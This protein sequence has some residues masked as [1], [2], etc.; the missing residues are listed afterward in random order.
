MYTRGQQSDIRS[1]PLRSNPLD[2]MW[3]T[4][5]FFPILTHAVPLRCSLSE[6]KVSVGIQESKPWILDTRLGLVCDTYWRK[7]L[8][9]VDA[10]KPVGEPT[11]LTKLEA[12]A[13]IFFF[14]KF[15]LQ[16]ASKNTDSRP[17]PLSKKIAP[18]HFFPLRPTL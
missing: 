1:L 9:I 14:Q 13:K 10:S 5:N 2:S 3:S 8:V 11:R 6:S 7:L 17:D 18:E 16:H 12:P 15:F 4:T